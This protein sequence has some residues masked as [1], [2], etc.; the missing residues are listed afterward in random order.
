VKFLGPAILGN[1]GE[2]L[3]YLLALGYGLG[4]LVGNI[5][6]MSYSLFLATG[7]TCSSAMVTATF[8]GLY[9]AYTRMEVQKTWDAM[10]ATPLTV[11]DIVLG[12]LLWGGTKGLFSSAAILTVAAFLGTGIHWHALLA[13]PILLLTGLCFAAMALLVT[14]FARN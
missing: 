9:S 8:E 2:P 3:L 1:F 4:S 11:Q 12:E 5:A 6:E 14:A 13:L 7:L 10:L